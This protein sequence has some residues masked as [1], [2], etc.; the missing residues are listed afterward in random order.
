MLGT[1]AKFVDHELQQLAQD[2]LQN[3]ISL[4]LLLDNMLIPV[5][6]IFV[7]IDVESLY[8]SIPQSEYVNSPP[9]TEDQTPSTQTVH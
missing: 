4:V 1:T 3:S 6:A 8:P 5:D 2:Y 7:T 9:D